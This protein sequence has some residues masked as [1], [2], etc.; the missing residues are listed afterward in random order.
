MKTETEIKLEWCQAERIV[1]IDAIVKLVN[2][3]ECIFN[4]QSFMAMLR[5]QRLVNKVKEL[6]FMK[7]AESNDN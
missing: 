4:D 2:E 6:E 7:E 5:A 3:F 1:A